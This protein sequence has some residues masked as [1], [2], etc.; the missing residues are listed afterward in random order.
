MF[1][2]GVTY[3][4]I[5]N[6]TNGATSGTTLGKD[7]AVGSVA[8]VKVADNKVYETDQTA[9]TGL[10]RL[11]QKTAGGQ[12]IYS[13]E[14]EMTKVTI[15]SKSYTA[16]TEQ[17]TYF[18]YNS[19][20]G[21]LGT[22][23]SGS[24]YVLSITLSSYAPGI[25]TSPLVKTIPHVAT[26]AKESDLAMGLAQSFHR[27]FDREPYKV[28]K[29]DVVSSAAVT[30]ANGFK[31]AQ[32]VTVVKGSLAVT[33]TTDVTY[34]AAGGE[35]LVVGDYLRIGS[36]GGGTALSSSVYEVTAISGVKVTLD[37]PVAE[38]SGT[39]TAVDGTSDIEVIPAATGDAS[40]FGFKFTGLN[41]FADTAFNPQNDFY[42]K[43]RFEVA[44]A[45]FDAGTVVTESAVASEGVGTAYEVAQFESKQA[46]NDGVGKYASAYPATV[47]RGEADLTT[48]GTYDTITIDGVK[49]EYTSATTGQTPVSKFS[50]IIRTKVALTGDD[51]D[52]ALGVTV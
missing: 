20:S 9:V 17:V 38:A 6:V 35:T 1:E 41:R 39:Y 34:Q 21:S 12:L 28:I 11:V 26:S 19:S 14:F 3:Q 32:D 31:N 27:V 23:V 13:P 8:V 51:V 44:S 48:P 2:N 36:V 10:F 37:R 43:T 24:T 4:Y 22:I 42:S 45:D 7:I 52:T 40:D 18:G 15:G 5:G 50:L 33:C 25:G 46:M 47:Y 16:A 29:C 49:N 30:A